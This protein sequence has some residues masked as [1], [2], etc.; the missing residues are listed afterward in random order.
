MK[1]SA[2][3][4]LFTRDIQLFFSGC[5]G[6]KS[7]LYLSSLGASCTKLVPGFCSASLILCGQAE[8]LHVLAVAQ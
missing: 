2:C 6:G 1:G 7:Q 3:S 5:A 4:F 8:E